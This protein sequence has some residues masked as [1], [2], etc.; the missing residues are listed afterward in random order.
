MLPFGKHELERILS[1]L[2]KCVLV[3]PESL[4]ETR[5]PIVKDLFASYYGKLDQLDLIQINGSI[6]YD[7]LL[8][9]LLGVVVL[10]RKAKHYEGRKT[11]ERTYLL[12]FTNLGELHWSLTLRDANF[13]A[14][15]LRLF[16][17]YKIKETM[18][19]PSAFK[20]FANAYRIGLYKKRL[21]SCES[22]RKRLW[23]RAMRRAKKLCLLHWDVFVYTWGLRVKGANNILP[24]YRMFL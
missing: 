9:P 4:T 24:D 16:P 23:A 18:K 21:E 6:V 19:A 7:D 22:V 2:P 13:R 1:C 11:N 12:P 14:D 5:L 10:V 3:I 15:M 20:A 17:Q 8:P